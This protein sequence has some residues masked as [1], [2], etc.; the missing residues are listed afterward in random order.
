VKAEFSQ[1]TKL[2]TLPFSKTNAALVFEDTA[3][4][5]ERSWKQRQVKK[6]DNEPR[7]ETDD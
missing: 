6:D 1:N 7:V 5:H 2:C 3:L 4:V